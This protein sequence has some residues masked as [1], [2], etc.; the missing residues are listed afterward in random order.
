MEIS[1]G[2]ATLLI[3][4]VVIVVLV[5]ALQTTRDIGKRSKSR[6]QGAYIDGGGFVVTDTT[7][8]HHHHN[9]DSS[10][11]HAADGGH[12]GGSDGGGGDGGH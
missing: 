4:S 5:F 9:A 7:T 3:A 8:S 10:H 12:S 2:W 11:G 6:D 1:G